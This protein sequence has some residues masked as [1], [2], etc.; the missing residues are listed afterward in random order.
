MRKRSGRSIFGAALLRACALAGTGFAAD[1]APAGLA[2]GSP[3]PDFSVP[4]LGGQMFRLSAETGGGRVVLLNFWGLRCGACIEEIPHLNVLAEKHRGKVTVVGVN[5]DAAGAE[6]LRDQMGRM[7]LSI[8]YPVLPDPEMRL[9]DMFGLAG[10]PLNVIVGKDGRLK[11]RREGF[12]AGDEK[13]LEQ[14]VVDAMGTP[15][16]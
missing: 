16:N 4:A 2:V 14:A 5:V 3:V 13:A 15:G 9:V 1:G 11:Y 10:A 6:T 8:A 12:E 7:Q